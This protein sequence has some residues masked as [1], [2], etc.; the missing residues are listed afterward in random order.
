M[1]T[2]DFELLPVRN[3]VPVCENPA[4]GLCTALNQVTC[5]ATT[6]KKILMKFHG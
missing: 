3:C 6:E 5:K 1:N 4:C 2:S